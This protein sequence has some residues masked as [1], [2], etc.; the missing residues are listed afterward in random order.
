MFKRS[1]ARRASLLASAGPILLALAE[2]YDDALDRLKRAPSR[3]LTDEPSGLAGWLGRS[4]V[5]MAG[6]TQAAPSRPDALAEAD[7]SGG[8]FRTG[9][10]AVIMVEGVL[11]PK[12]YYDWWDE[13]WTPGYADIG[14][15]VLEAQRDPAISAV[16]LHID[17]PGGL[18][19]GL[20]ELGQLLR[21]NSAR[22]GA[23]PLVAFCATAY[24]AAYWIAACCDAVYAPRGAGIGSIG[25]RMGWFDLSAM[26][27]K[28]G[29]RREEFTSGKFKDSG[30]AYRPVRDDERAR[31][32]AEISTYAGFFFDA[33][34]AGRD[35]SADAL[36]AL[37]AATF[38]AGASGDLDPQAIGLIDA[39]L[40][41]HE[42]IEAAR[43]L[44]GAGTGRTA[45]AEN[46]AA[47]DKESSMGVEAEI[48]ALRTKAAKGD[49]EAKRRLAA[50]GVP[51][52]A[53]K[54]GRTSAE[55]E[56]RTSEDEEKDAEDEDDPEASEEEEEAVND[57]DTDASDDE[58]E[59]EDEDEPKSQANA[60][61]KIARIAARQGKPGIGAQLAVDVAA[62]ETSYKAALRTL[63]SAAREGSPLATA[64]AGGRDGLKPA[65]SA[66]GNP[67]A[68]RTKSLM[69][70]VDRQVKRKP[71]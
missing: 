34:S 58:E 28:E 15:A 21:E 68:S 62:G 22:A 55:G 66:D 27:E 11:T 47:A 48:A 54:A 40:S 56:D 29:V 14:S 17:S 12:G 32:E 33:V 65:R 8:Y 60:G 50:M 7:W 36:R 1:G 61:R 51:V 9:D 18:V 23:K 67:A 19:S 42:A 53:P 63:K 6:L 3:A 49:A 4:A 52:T 37:E 45:P 10:L 70:A 59:A 38:T 31:F 71:A 25:V 30:S 57:E 16:L 5:A 39:V 20:D 26:L 13:C 2:G 64:M 69:A 46:P 44:A 24:S 43:L 41:G 35:M